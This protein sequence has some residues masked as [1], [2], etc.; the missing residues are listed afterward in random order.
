MGEAGLLRKGY[1]R[2]R[3]RSLLRPSRTRKRHD[4][5]IR[6]YSPHGM[7]R[8]RL[9]HD[10]WGEGCRRPPRRR[11]C[12]QRTM[13]K[14]PARSEAIE[15]T[16][17]MRARV[18]GPPS[19]VYEPHVPVPATRETSVSF[20]RTWRTVHTYLSEKRAPPEPSA[21]TAPGPDKRAIAPRL[22]VP[23]YPVEGMPPATVTMMP[24]ALIYG[25][26]RACKCACE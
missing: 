18:A 4:C 11:F 16:L 22:P 15:A 3:E 24:F 23:K 17:P 8:V 1:T 5:S 13:R 2:S 12:P 7:K 20:P 21:A 19:P 26:G 14:P 9:Q 25:R 6:E 10:T